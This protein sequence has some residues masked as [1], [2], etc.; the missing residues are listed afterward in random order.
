MRVALIFSLS[1]LLGFA[2]T[3][4]SH[5]DV[6]G[7]WNFDDTH[8]NQAGPASDGALAYGTS[9]FSTDVP[10]AIG[11]GKSGSFDG[12]SAIQVPTTGHPMDSNDFNLSYFIKR[13]AQNGPYE[14]ITSR[15]GNTHETAIGQ[16]GELSSYGGWSTLGTANEGVWTHVAWVNTSFV[17]QSLYVD[18]VLQPG[19]PSLNPVLSG[20]LFL[21]GI[22]SNNGESYNGLLDDVLLWD[23]T[24]NPLSTGEIA[25]IANNGVD[26]F[27][28]QAPPAPVFTIIDEEG[29]VEA[30]PGWGGNSNEGFNK[31]IRYSNDANATATWTF[32]GLADGEYDVLASWSL[33]PN[34]SS[35][36]SYTAGGNPAV[37]VNQEKHG[38][39]LYLEGSPASSTYLFDYLDGP[40]TVSGGSLTV[41][42]SNNNS[43]GN[44]Y[45]IADAVAIRPAEARTYIMDNNSADYAT[46]FPHANGEGFL[47]GIHHT[48]G[49]AA[50]ADMESTWSFTDLADGMYKVYA[51]WSTHANRTQAAPFSV[52]DGNGQVGNT[53]PV[54]QEGNPYGNTRDLNDVDTANWRNLGSYT[55]SDGTL[56]VKLNGV[57]N[58][59]G[60]DYVIADAIRIEPI[61]PTELRAWIGVFHA[62]S[63]TSGDPW[64]FTNPPTNTVAN[65]TNPGWGEGS[66]GDQPVAGDWDGDGT[67]G[68][69]VFRSTGGNNWYFSNDRATPVTDFS[70]GPWGAGSLGD[71]AV[72]GDWDGD[73]IDGVGVFRSSDDGVNW[74]LS[75][76]AASLDSDYSFHYGAGS[77]GDLP[78]AGDWD[79]D[80]LDTVG[81]FRTTN[82]MWYLS[83]ILSDSQIAFEFVFGQTG[84]IP[85]AEDWDGD[86]MDDVGLFRPST[87]E[88]FFDTNFDGV[89]DF[90]NPSYGSGALGDIPLA[91]H[92]LA[93]DSSVP[94]PTSWMLLA[95]GSLGLVFYRRRKRICP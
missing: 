43:G 61:A 82:N 45:L 67:D 57:D 33:H 35:D 85:V 13:G 69:A 79:G 25:F 28:N 63:S 78:V 10:A 52:S 58:A 59:S 91:G 56:T 7:Y 47:A 34:R 20:D 55:V 16:N 23:N 53:V 71:I 38:T 54:N 32:N 4:R 18:G 66:L 8:A 95:I 92:F 75:D 81:V 3:V 36:V 80:G 6:I 1:L 89:A 62:G 39:G 83:N 11:S 44:D 60:T 86:G 70:S 5:A 42:A 19:T 90:H 24:S 65:A 51:T 29:A 93:A 15:P 37:H 31:D 49:G 46:D 22:A 41:T 9:V 30:G 48:A 50:S 2:L 87:G 94:E 21:G 74:F 12:G 88:W 27:L 68:I 14:R 17:G 72:A 76:D 84:D 40:V 64:S 26:A 77:L 73:G